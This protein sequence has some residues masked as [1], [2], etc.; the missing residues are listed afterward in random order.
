M[1]GLK[2]EEEEEFEHNLVRNVHAIRF[3]KT[4]DKT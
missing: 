4:S 1:F 3:F 2:K